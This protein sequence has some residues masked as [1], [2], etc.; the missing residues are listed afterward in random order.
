MYEMLE[1]AAHLHLFAHG[2]DDGGYQWQAGTGPCTIRYVSKTV[3]RAHR[4]G[5]P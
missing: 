2:K 5:V 1:R 3:I 4:R